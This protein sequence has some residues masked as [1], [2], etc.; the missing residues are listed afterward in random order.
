HDANATRAARRAKRG[1]RDA[2]RIASFSSLASAIARDESG[3][4]GAAD[5]EMRPDHDALAAAVGADVLDAFDTL[6]AAG[7]IAEAAAIASEP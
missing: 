3:V 1:L 6:D 4:A 7:A 5:D 2:W